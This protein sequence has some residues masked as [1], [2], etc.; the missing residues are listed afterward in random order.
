MTGLRRPALPTS[1][2]E[3]AAEKNSMHKTL[4][5]LPFAFLSA[6]GASL[7]WSN[8]TVDA[9][10]T[11]EPIR[12]GDEAKL[13]AALDA[14]DADSISKDINVIAS[15]EY[16]GRDTPSD[17][18]TKTAE[19]I[20]GRLEELGLTKGYKDSY[21]YPYKLNHK[22]IIPEKSVLRFEA[23]GKK[24]DLE[25][26][27]AYTAF[28][29][30]LQDSKGSGKVVWFGSGTKED[31]AKASAKGRFAMV[32]FTPK[33]TGRNMNRDIA[34]LQ[35]RAREQNAIGLI[36]L[37]APGTSPQDAAIR[38]KGTSERLRTGY[39]SYPGGRSRGN[40]RSRPAF[41]TVILSSES[42]DSV[43]E[44]IGA[45]DNSFFP[46][47]KKLDLRATTQHEFKG[48]DGQVEV[49]NVVGL[50]EGSDP[51]LKREVIILSAHYD[52]VGWREDGQIHNGADDNGSG[53]CGLLALAGALR[54]YGPMKRTVLL[55]WV[56]GEEKGLYGSKAW[57]EKPWLPRTFR[58]VAN[59]NI[60]MIGRNAPDKLMI[61]PTKEGRYSKMYNGIVRRAEELREQ[62]GFAKLESAD[63][64]YNRS[65]QANFAKLGI[66][67][68][69]LFTD[70]HEDYHEVT[71]VPAKIDADKIRRVTRLVL[72]ILNTL[73]EKKLGV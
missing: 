8:S 56:S 53:T 43:G 22:G 66:P 11:P 19:F 45:Q 68:A 23:K 16:G 12:V 48:D 57:S 69:F 36:I 64:Y 25:F 58:P 27:V 70:V 32:S 46:A 71:D 65:D 55:I 61:T 4:K 28:A 31:F 17:G 40:R 39:V 41:P 26:G 1:S 38:I 33:A 29:P 34:A 7:A 42:A 30:S 37:P 13:I 72:R 63:V 59:I 67:V 35:Q 18:L 49:N 62:E 6:L 44:M 24:L 47:G 2:L 5:W 10:E 51:K 3:E 73:Q 50:W 20:A 60:D 52:H 21:L 14:I 15:D 54:T 9:A